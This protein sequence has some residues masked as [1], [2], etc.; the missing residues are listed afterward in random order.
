MKLVKA[1]A[2]V[3]GMTGLS[4]VAGF[5]RDILTAAILGAGPIADAFFV[6]LKLPNFFRRVTAE[7]A[8]SVAFVPLYSE[9][10]EQ[11]GRAQADDFAANAFMVMALI[12]AGVTLLGLAVMPYI[13]T[14][15]AP[16]FGDDALRFDAAVAFSRITFPYLLL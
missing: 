4:R 12:L 14:V 2:T 8:F 5:A 15:I 7:G 6:A 9:K 13:I 3:A 1:M 10:L 16:G 11:Q